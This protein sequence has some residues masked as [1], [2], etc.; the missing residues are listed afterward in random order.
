M[1]DGGPFLLF[2]DNSV[3]RC[4]STKSCIQIISDYLFFSHGKPF[5]TKISSC[6]HSLFHLHSH[7]ANICFRPPLICRIEKLKE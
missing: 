7:H 4:I 5:S 6:M 1:L 2:D 3:H